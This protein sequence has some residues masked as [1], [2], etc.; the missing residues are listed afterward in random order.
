MRCSALDN[1]VVAGR[2]SNLCSLCTR[3]VTVP[4]VW[5]GLVGGV[6]LGSRDALAGAFVVDGGA[7]PIAFDVEFEDGGPVHQA[8][9]G[10]DAHG[11]L[12]EDLVRLAE[13]LVGA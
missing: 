7:S 10:S 6:D 11:G 1:A 3:Y 2:W 8:V 5:S 12:G 4:T 9:D 13:R